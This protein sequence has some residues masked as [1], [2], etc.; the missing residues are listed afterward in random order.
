MESINNDDYIKRPMNSFMI[1]SQEMRPSIIKSNPN[2]INSEISIM[3]GQLWLNM[4]KKQ[5]E[6][7]YKKAE[8]L[9][10][11]HME[12]YPD[13]KYNPQQKEKKKEKHKSDNIENENIN[14]EE[15]KEKIIMQLFKR[16]YSNSNKSR[17]I[18]TNNFK[19]EY[20]KPFTIIKTKS[21]AFYD[22]TYLQDRNKFT[23]A[24]D[25]FEYIVN[26]L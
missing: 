16:N 20:Y 5:K 14:E 17:I 26:N 13:Y 15:N 24:I 1:W 23:N 10:L 6:I 19:S 4:S 21:N 25:Y 7:Y 11:Q 18:N 8:T 22:N 3:L 9:K 12:L 2:V